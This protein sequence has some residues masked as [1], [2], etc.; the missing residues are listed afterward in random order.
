MKSNEGPKWVRDIYEEKFRM[1][2]KGDVLQGPD[3]NEERMDER[4][5]SGDTGNSIVRLR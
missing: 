5:Q 2:D 4:V 3:Y 1:G